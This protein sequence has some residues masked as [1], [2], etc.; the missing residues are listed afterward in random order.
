MFKLT[1]QWLNAVTAD[2]RIQRVDVDIEGPGD[3]TGS[4]VAGQLRNA[5]GTAGFDLPQGLY[6]VRLMNVKVAGWSVAVEVA[7]IVAASGVANNAVVNVAQGLKLPGVYDPTAPTGE[8]TEQFVTNAIAAATANMATDSEVASAVAPLAAK[9]YVDNLVA[10]A[11]T[12]PVTSG[13]PTGAAAD[14]TLAIDSTGP[15]LYARVAGAWV[16]VSTPAA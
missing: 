11:I 7:T 3:V 15:T 13:A 2:V 8:V 10:D 16:A 4:V 1:G 6:R 9:S 5:S 12:L 14:G